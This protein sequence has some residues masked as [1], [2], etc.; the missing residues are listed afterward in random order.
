LRKSVL[1]EAFYWLVY[2]YIEKLALQLYCWVDLSSDDLYDIDEKYEYAK[3]MAF[4]TLRGMAN[5]ANL[6][7]TLRDKGFYVIFLGYNYFENL[8]QPDLLI[9]KNGKTAL[10]EVKGR[11]ATEEALTRVSR[12]LKKRH[13]E[14][15]RSYEWIS[16]QLGVPLYLA[17]ID[18]NTGDW[19]FITTTG[20]PLTLR[21]FVGGF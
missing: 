7:D 20:K 1:K 8:A 18:K 16:K 3:N 10:V 17:Y 21:K 14:Y 12:D 6:M 19:K 13:G 4:N 15:G 9:A 5:T 11:L 2:D